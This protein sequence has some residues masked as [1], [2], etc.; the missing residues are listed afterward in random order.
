MAQGKTKIKQK[1]PAN[2]KTKANKT[3]KKNAPFPQ[4]KREE[5]QI[6]AEHALTKIFQLF[7]VPPFRRK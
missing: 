5:T 1:L 2:A 4:R 6:R 3:N 7:Q